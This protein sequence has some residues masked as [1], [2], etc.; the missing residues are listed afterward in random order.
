ME[1]EESKEER[2]AVRAGAAVFCE[3]VEEARGAERLE[4][5]EEGA[6]APFG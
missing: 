5:A 2:A 4:E 3:E 6:T 1:S